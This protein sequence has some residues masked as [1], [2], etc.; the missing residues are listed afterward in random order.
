[1]RVAAPNRLVVEVDAPSVA[2][3][4]DRDST[5]HE[6]LA[7]ERAR[8]LLDRAAAEQS[9]GDGLLTDPAMIRV[10][11]TMPMSTLAGFGMAGFTHDRLDELVAQL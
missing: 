3:P 5:L 8:S 1:M 10:I 2:P 9:L 7:D 4:V 11:G 6:W